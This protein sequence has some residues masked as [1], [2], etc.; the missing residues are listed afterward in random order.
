MPA[1]RWSPEKLK[2]GCALRCTPELSCGAGEQTNSADQTTGKD[3]EIR[4]PHP[5]GLRISRS[6]QVGC[7]VG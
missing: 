1:R 4:S 6:A 3:R 7:G 2:R 5:G